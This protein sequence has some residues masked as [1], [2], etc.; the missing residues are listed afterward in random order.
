MAGIDP[1]ALVHPSAEIEDGAAI[2][3]DTHIWRRVHV[4][5][6]A[7]IGAGVQLGANVFVDAGVRIGDRVKIQNNVSV[8]AGVELEDEAF[9]GPAA[10]FTNDLNPRATGEWQLT[11]TF[12]RRGASVGANATIVCGYELGEHCLVAA[13]AVVTKNVAAHQLVL[14]NPARPAGWVCRCG[15]VVSRD[16]QRPADLVCETCTHGE[17]SDT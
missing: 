2:G 12:V 16:A 3:A 14:G 7:V 6:G 13:G 8:Y 4:R 9:V 17:A 1:T 5:T 10:V 15:Q 11:P